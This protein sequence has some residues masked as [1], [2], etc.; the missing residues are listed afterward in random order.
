VDELR[1]LGINPI[2]MVICNLHPVE[3]TIRHGGNLKA[4]LDE[5]DIGGPALIRAAAKNFENVVVITNRRKYDQVLK[6]LREKGDVSIQTRHTLAMEAFRKTARYDQAI[7]TF[8]KKQL[9]D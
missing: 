6:E 1:K 2:D 3:K 5:I 9:K 4:V 7:Y 8:L